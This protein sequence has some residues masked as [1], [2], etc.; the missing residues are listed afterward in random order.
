MQEGPELAAQSGQ[1]EAC[2]SGVSPDQRRQQVE[3]LTEVVRAADETVAV[4]I[5]WGRLT[6]ALHD[7]W[8]HW[9]CAI[10]VAKR[11][12]S[13]MFHK[14]SLLDDPAG[15]LVGEGRY[16]RQV[17]YEQVAAHPEAVGVFVQEAI[18][19]QTDM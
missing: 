16:L 7:D 14:G 8:H 1:V 17:R 9:L 18:T 19:R 15:L 10:A 2:L 4:A 6:F 13:L 5:K 3:W 12:V 11:G